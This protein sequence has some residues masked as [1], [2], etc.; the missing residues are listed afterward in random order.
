MVHSGDQDLKS[1]ARGI[2]ILQFVAISLAPTLPAQEAAPLPTASSATAP[3]A[4]PAYE[5][6]G[7]ARSG[8]TPLPGV[9]VTAANTLTGKKYAAATNSEGKFGLSGMTRGRY[10]IRMEFMGFAAFTA[11]RV[12]RAGARA[13]AIFRA[14]PSMARGP[15]GRRSR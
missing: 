13:T 7:S 15:R 1:I 8:K 5:I 12:G 2:L 4:A 3:A 14:C 9:T 11:G 6:N 10:V